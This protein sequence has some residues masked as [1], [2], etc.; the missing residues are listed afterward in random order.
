MAF[1]LHRKIDRGLAVARWLIGRIGASKAVR[2]HHSGVDATLQGIVETLDATVVDVAFA[3][4][5][6]AAPSTD[7]T[8]FDR[9]DPQCLRPGAIV[10]AIGIHPEDGDALA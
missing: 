6:L 8:F 5:D 4:Q 10:L 1:A 7:V 2:S 9:T 3:A